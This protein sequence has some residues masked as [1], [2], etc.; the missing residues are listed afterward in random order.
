MAITPNL[1]QTQ[2]A[3]LAVI[4]ERGRLVAGWGGYSST[5]TVR[6]LQEKGL[7]RLKEYGPGQWEAFS[8]GTR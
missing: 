8:T 1:T 7:V 4:R 5:L 3:Y 2:K 6:L